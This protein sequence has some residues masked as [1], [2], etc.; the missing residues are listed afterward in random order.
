MERQQEKFL[1]RL[2]WGWCLASPPS[3]LLPH[4]SPPAPKPF[5]FQAIQTS[6]RTTYRKPRPRGRGGNFRKCW[7]KS[8][9]S[10]AGSGKFHS[11]EG[12]PGCPCGSAEVSLLRDC[13]ESVPKLLQVNGFRNSRSSLVA[14]QLEDG[15]GYMRPC[16]KTF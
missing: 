14:D 1:P 13:W 7:Q 3:R 8:L 9:H 11:A 5:A 6:H 12:R 4:S 2:H 15:G 10:A 16:L